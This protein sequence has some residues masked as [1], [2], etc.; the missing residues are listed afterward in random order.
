MNLCGRTERRLEDLKARLD[1]A[2]TTKEQ[3][4]EVAARQQGYQA[5]LHIF[6][7]MGKRP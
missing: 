5:Q 7:N 1:G 4:A 6:D 3:H 2:K